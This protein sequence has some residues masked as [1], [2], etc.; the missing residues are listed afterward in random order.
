[1]ASAA[2]ALAS[3]TRSA[4]LARMARIPVAIIGAS[5]Y[6]GAEL[7]R[8]LLP[9][10]H[11]E[12]VGLYARKSA[13]EPIRRVFPHLAPCDLVV[14]SFDADAVAAKAKVAF[15]CLPHGDSALVVRQLYDRGL[16][17]LDLSADFRLRDPAA[18]KQWYGGH[19]HPEPA[20]LEQAV[21]G[22]P[23]RHRERLRGA[24]LV[25][26]P[27][28]YPTSAVLPLAPLLAAGLVRSAG[29]VV[30]AKSGVS[31]AG[32]A[33]AQAY[34]FPDIAEGIR[35]Y[36]IAGTHRHTPEIEQEL[37][38]AT[39]LPARDLHLLFTPNLVPM[40]R[41]IL[42]CCYALP[43]EREL[44]AHA[45]RDA[46]VA[47]YA[48]E[49]FVTVVDADQPPD[50]AHVRGS[51]RAQVGAWFDPR[52]ERVLAIGAIDNLTKGA[53]GQAVQCMNLALG[54]DETAGLLGGAMYP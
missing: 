1:M 7:L 50:T 20:L 45:Y 37:A 14:E 22:L 33:P 36:K 24:R 39:G 16:T 48:G 5:G 19:D 32:R 49:P 2:P 43:T 18:Y 8:L 23:E 3:S 10:P 54:F 28:C 38:A 40:T 9:H 4:R 17:V 51:N 21:Y 15:T 29:I 30:D 44:P 46:L 6:T 34:H 13:G 42:A 27:G 35:A 41:G 11:V 53:S 47:A 26:C 31:G 52:S 12:V 25:A